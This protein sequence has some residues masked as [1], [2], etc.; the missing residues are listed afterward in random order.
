MHTPRDPTIVTR[1]EVLAGHGMAGPRGI[2]NHS[3]DG[4][5]QGVCGVPH[6]ILGGRSVLLRA[7][8]GRATW[9]FIL[10]LLQKSLG[11]EGRGWDRS[12]WVVERGAFTSMELA[13]AVACVY[14]DTAAYL[15]TVAVYVNVT[16]SHSLVN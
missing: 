13:L 16:R 14:R 4:A 2:T 10:A 3:H 12:V 8:R 5:Y 7:A 9:L 15:H 1:E 11:M 6:I